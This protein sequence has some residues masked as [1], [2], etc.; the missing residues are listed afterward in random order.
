MSCYAGDFVAMLDPKPAKDLEFRWV[1]EPI[2]LQTWRILTSFL[3]WAYDEHKCEAQVRLAYNET[4]KE[5]RIGVLP[6]TIMAGLASKEYETDKDRE[7]CFDEAGIND[8]FAFV[9]TVHQHCNAAAFQSGT[10]HADELKQP[11]FHVTL[12]HLT[13]DMADYHSRGSFRG[14][15]YPEVNDTD[16]LPYDKK[17]ILSLKNLPDF[18]EEWKERLK[19]R[20]TTTS[21]YSNQWNNWQGRGGN[22]VVHGGAQDYAYCGGGYGKPDFLPKEAEQYCKRHLWI[23]TR[24][25]FWDYMIAVYAC[26]D[27]ADVKKD[28]ALSSK[29]SLAYKKACCEAG[30]YAHWLSEKRVGTVEVDKINDFFHDLLATGKVT[31]D[32]TDGTWTVTKT[33]LKVDPDSLYRQF[34][35]NGLTPLTELQRKLKRTD[36]RAVTLGDAVEAGEKKVEEKKVEEIDYEYLDA[37]E[38]NNI[39]ELLPASP[40]KPTVPQS[41]LIKAVDTLLSEDGTFTDDFQTALTEAVERNG[42]QLF[43]TEKGFTPTAECQKAVHDL[44]RVV[45]RSMRTQAFG[46]VVA[47]DFLRDSLDIL[48]WDM[49]MM[50]TFWTSTANACSLLSVPLLKSAQETTVND[51]E[52]LIKWLEPHFLELLV[53]A[54]R[55]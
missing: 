34:G 4:T 44:T 55:G 50:D 14:V 52:G 42:D 26:Y 51:I 32:G 17:A 29:K 35:P 46:R 28:K 47:D 36:S 39:M 49:A 11:G 10:D 45:I 13:K 1:A 24:E 8:G 53:K 33:N 27:E 3:K 40:D 19:K 31:F 2:P 9:G 16:W 41:N 15:M 5:W 25:Y 30:K 54:K 43:T 20:T 6:Q 12:G 38:F 37:L 48:G 7:K 23:K 21:S 22:V 18:P